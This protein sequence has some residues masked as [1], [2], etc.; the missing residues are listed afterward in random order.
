MKSE[1]GKLHLP[2]S[3]LARIEG[4]PFEMDDAGR[5]GAPV[6]IFD[7]SVLK[8]VRFNE[9]NEEVVNLMRWLKGKLPAPE[10]ILYEKD[11]ERQYLLM[12]KVTGTMSC[13][14]YYLE[15]PDVL[16]PILAE[17][18]QMLWRI[19][20]S[21]CPRIRDLDADLRDARYNV[22]HGLVDVED[23]EPTTFGEGGFKDPAEL[24]SWLENHRPSYEPVFSHGD[25]CL[26]NILIR[27]G[28]VSGYID[29]AT[30]GVG[31]KWRDIALCYRSFKHNAEGRYGGKVYPNCDPDQ[32]F[33]AL[34]IEPDWDKIRYYILLDELF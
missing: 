32:L 21:D 3:I 1:L 34:G 14:S 17:G 26:P 23:A 28:K 25:F 11:A 18:L 24:L 22:E 30:A 9:K 15:H 10:V 20:I 29:M 27:D 12:S 33:E 6:L 13:D 5:S 31:D 16:L 7:D 2:K 4:K 19:D 8:I